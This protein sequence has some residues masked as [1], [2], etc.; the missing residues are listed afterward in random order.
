ML[1]DLDEGTRVMKDG[2]D[3]EYCG[4]SQS[5]HPARSACQKVE[6]PIKFLLFFLAH[7]VLANVRPTPVVKGL[8]P[9]G[10]V[11][12]TDWYNERSSGR[13]GLEG[14]RGSGT[15]GLLLDLDEGAL[16]VFKIKND[17][18][19]G[20]I[21]DGLGGEYC[22]FVSVCSACMISVSKGLAPIMFC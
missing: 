13:R 15:A 6:F 18:R 9:A 12:W 8:L 1:L 2:L 21:K 19:L 4:L 17:R 7:L 20:M 5:T 14:V 16:S 22:W 11:D 10:L 3:G